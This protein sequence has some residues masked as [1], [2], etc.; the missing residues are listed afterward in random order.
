MLK[1]IPVVVVVVGV[2]VAGHA[3]VDRIDPMNVDDAQL[4]KKKKSPDEKQDEEA[5]AETVAVF[6]PPKEEEH[7]DR[8]VSISCL[9]VSRLDLGWGRWRV[10]KKER[11]M[12]GLRVCVCVLRQREKREK[13][14]GD[15][16]R[17][18]L[19]SL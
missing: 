16:K 18:N 17:E 4:W 14:K 10:G 3:T 7:Y 9:W 19:S 12:L 11:K 13:A 2:G 15:E 1:L 5:G 8:C 6:D